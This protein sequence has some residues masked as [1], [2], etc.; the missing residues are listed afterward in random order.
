L[1]APIV[2]V[3]LAPH[4]I[5]FDAPDGEPAHIICLLLTPQHD[6]GA[7][8]QILADIARSFS[9]EKFRDRIMRIG[10]FTELLALLKSQPAP[11]AG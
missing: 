2:A 5:D 6:Q 10:T 4:G 7:Q 8:L 3:G 1:K 11:H 9:D